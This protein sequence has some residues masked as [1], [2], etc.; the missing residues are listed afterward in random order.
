MVRHYIP[1]F[2][3]AEVLKIQIYEADSDR[4]VITHLTADRLPVAPRHV[5]ESGDH[6]LIEH[7]T[8][9]PVTDSTV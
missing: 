7:L 4:Q 6:L 1:H 3:K 9:K 2:G 8:A 5:L